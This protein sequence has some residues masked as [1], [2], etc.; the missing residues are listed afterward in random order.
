[1]QVNLNVKRITMYLTEAEYES[2]IS[3]A[4]KLDSSASKFTK[5]ALKTYIKHLDKHLQD[6][7]PIAA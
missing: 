7:E 5:Q 1:M 2:I 4:E 3:K 6:A